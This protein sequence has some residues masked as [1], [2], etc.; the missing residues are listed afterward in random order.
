MKKFYWVNNNA[1]DTVC[2]EVNGSLIEATSACQGFGSEG[3]F[4]KYCDPSEE[5]SDWSYDADIGGLEDVEDFGTPV[6]YRHNTG[7]IHIIDDVQFERRRGYW[8]GNKRWR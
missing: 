2:V 3:D 6:A 5:M 1:Y 7:E 4:A 8:R